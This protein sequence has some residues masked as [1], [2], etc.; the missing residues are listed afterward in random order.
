MHSR[1]LPRPTVTVNTSR[2]NLLTP[3]AQAAAQPPGTRAC[4]QPGCMLVACSTKPPYVH[5][6]SPLQQPASITALT[7]APSWHL[8]SAAPQPGCMLSAYRISQST[9]TSVRL[10]NSPLQQPASITALTAAPSS[11]LCSAA[12]QPL[13]LAGTPRGASAA[14]RRGRL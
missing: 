7:A 10:P 1:T 9:K 13:A 4:M 8:C 12:P 11:H 14:A 2:S 3:I 5:L 6:T